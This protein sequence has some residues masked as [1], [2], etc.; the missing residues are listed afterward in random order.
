MKTLSVLSSRFLD[1]ARPV[2]FGDFKPDGEPDEM[3]LVRRGDVLESAG[4]G[5]R[6]I[7]KEVHDRLLMTGS[8]KRSGG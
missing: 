4:Y 7:E 3:I 6:P 8:D 5:S 2:G 1:Q